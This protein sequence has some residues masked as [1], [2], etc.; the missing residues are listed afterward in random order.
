MLT[1]TGEGGGRGKLL[2]LLFS[3]Q[4]INKFCLKFKR[5]YIKCS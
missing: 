3:M 1:P 2:S 5:P 4:G